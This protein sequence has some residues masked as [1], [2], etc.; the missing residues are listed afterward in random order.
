MGKLKGNSPGLCGKGETFK[1]LTSPA[2]ECNFGKITLQKL[3]LSLW[4]VKTL[5]KSYFMLLTFC[6]INNNKLN[7]E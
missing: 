6:F 2:V 7:E 3:S 4:H 1:G 5:D